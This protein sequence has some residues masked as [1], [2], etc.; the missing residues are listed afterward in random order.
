MVLPLAFLIGSI[1]GILKAKKRNGNKF[2]LLQ[3][4][5]TY[6]IAFAMVTLVS[7]IIF[8]RFGLFT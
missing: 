2:D 5:A 7:T 8:Q 3:Y 4:G 6:G 1:F